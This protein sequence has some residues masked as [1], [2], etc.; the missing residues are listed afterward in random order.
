MTDKPDRRNSNAPPRALA[1]GTEID[2]NREISTMADAETAVSRADGASPDPGASPAGKRPIGL[3]LLLHLGKPRATRAQI[4]VALLCALLGFAFVTQV[5]S[6][7]NTG[8]SSARQADLIDVL[9]NL[10]AKSE[11]LQSQIADEQQALAKLTGGTGQTEAALEEAQQRATTLRILAG[12]VGATGPGI[13][14]RI[15]DPR[16]NVTADVLLDALEEL[17]DAG[18]EAV[19]IRGADGSAVRLVASSYFVDVQG[20]RGIVVDGTT[21]APPYDV[22]AIGDPP[23]LAQAMGIPGGVLDTLKSKEANGAV[24]QHQN[25]RITSLHLVTPPEYARPATSPSTA[26]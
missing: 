3:A 22:L 1:T 20:G 9:D 6:Q 8:L 16:N 5:H 11:Q 10:S 23:T 4:L 19:E 25:V 17:R 15:S 12:T 7:A 2:S 21:L 13:E 14:L 24:T 18:A 26:N